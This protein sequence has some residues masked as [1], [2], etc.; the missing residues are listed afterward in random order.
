[1]LGKIQSAEMSLAFRKLHA[2]GAQVKVLGENAG[3]QIA[4]LRGSIVIPNGSADINGQAEYIIRTPC[5]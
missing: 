2:N 1:M 3:K 4:D 5:S